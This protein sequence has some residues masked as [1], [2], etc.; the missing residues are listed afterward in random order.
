MKLNK[1]LEGIFWTLSSAG[2][3]YDVIILDFDSKY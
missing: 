1:I 2:F 3:T